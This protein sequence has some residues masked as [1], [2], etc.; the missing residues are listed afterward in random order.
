MPK[1]A[2]VDP[3]IQALNLGQPQGALQLPTTRKPTRGALG[4]AAPRG[5]RTRMPPQLAAAS[6]GG[7]K[8]KP[9]AK[10]RKAASK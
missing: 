2:A 5:A 10:K 8:A 4:G 3:Q 9:T 6:R 7:A 1:K